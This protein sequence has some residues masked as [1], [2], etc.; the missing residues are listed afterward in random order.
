MYLRPLSDI[1][2]DVED[3][4]AFL[5]KQPPYNEQMRQLMLKKGGENLA[6]L[7]QAAATRPASRPAEAAQ[8]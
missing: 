8:D 4:I 3:W 1:E 2:R 7:K 6:R 5:E